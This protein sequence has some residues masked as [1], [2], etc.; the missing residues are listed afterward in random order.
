MP[1]CLR[2]QYAD[3][4]QSDAFAKVVSMFVPFR[5]KSFD[6]CVCKMVLCGAIGLG[7]IAKAAKGIPDNVE[8]R[9]VTRNVEDIGDVLSDAESGMSGIDSVGLSDA[10][11]NPGVAVLLA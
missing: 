8:G 10:T 11:S 7:N 6:C 9:K 3:G 2:L 5:A 4:S 1:T